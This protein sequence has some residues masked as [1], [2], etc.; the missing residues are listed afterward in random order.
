VANFKP[1]YTVAVS[2]LPVAGGSAS[3]GG[4]FAAGSSVTVT[5]TA[6]TGY[7]F[8]NWTEGATVVSGS[9]SY[10]FPLNGN[11]ALVANFTVTPT[12]G[13]TF[14]NPGTITIS[15]NQA[16]N[17]Y[18]S[19]IHVAGL[20][21]TIT[22]VTATL[23]NLSHA[24]SDDIDVLLVAPSGRAVLLM[25]DAGGNTSLSGVTLKFDD[26]ATSSLSDKKQIVSGTYKPTDFGASR[27][28]FQSPAPNAA[29]GVLLSAINGT[30][31][32]GDW[33]LFVV[34]DQNPNAGRINGG[35]SLALTTTAAMASPVSWKRIDNP[36]RLTAELTGTP[37]SHDSQVRITFSA[38]PGQ[39]YV[40]QRSTDLASWE[41]VAEIV[42]QTGKYSFTDTRLLLDTTQFYRASRL[43][44][45]E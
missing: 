18:P 7:Q 28:T 29:Y 15:D 44:N 45:I 19:T 37:G 13:L 33:R 41:T 36:V 22:K 10:T 12:T 38:E 14:V 3:G 30:D 17:P 24:R 5:A 32:N 21:G 6:N 27:D 1:L 2:A 11:R 25:S 4:T 34:D 23:L 40:V 8:A 20:A 39:T 16:A 26:A 43:T 31:P 35:W 42:S 9:A